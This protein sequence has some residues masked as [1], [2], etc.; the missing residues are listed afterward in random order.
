MPEPL[1][2]PARGARWT[3]AW[4][5]DAAAYGG[6]GPRAADVARGWNVPGECASLYIGTP[7]DG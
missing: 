3:L 4:S 7:N 5:S 2:A 6:L 1:L